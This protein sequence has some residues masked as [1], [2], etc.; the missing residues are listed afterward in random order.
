[1]FKILKHN[2]FLDLYG[3]DYCGFLLSSRDFEELPLYKVRCLGILGAHNQQLLQQISESLPETVLVIPF[4]WYTVAMAL[5][6]E[7]RGND[8]ISQDFDLYSRLGKTFKAKKVH[9][10]KPNNQGGED[11]Q[12]EAGIR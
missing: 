4:H 3:Q 11:G 1:M 8:R 6:P 9:N 7:L 10:N 2:F 12:D 5:S